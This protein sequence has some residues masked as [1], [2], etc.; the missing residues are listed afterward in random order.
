MERLDIDRDDFGNL[1]C[2]NEKCPDQIKKLIST[3]N[4]LTTV[5]NN[6]VDTNIQF[7]KED[8]ESIT[9]MSLV[10]GSIVSLD[11]CK[12]SLLAFKGETVEELPKKPE[13]V[14][15]KKDSVWTRMKRLSF[16]KRMSH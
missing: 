1:V 3:I 11:S 10:E 2:K 16:L 13:P 7:V 8:K 14:Q 12:S 4:S 9:V 15:K 6:C 5:L